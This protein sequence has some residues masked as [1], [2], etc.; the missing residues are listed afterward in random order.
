MTLTTAEFIAGV[1]VLGVHLF[2][3]N[4]KYEQNLLYG[5]FSS[6]DNLRQGFT[7]AHFTKF[8]LARYCYALNAIASCSGTRT[9]TSSSMGLFATLLSTSH[10]IC[11]YKFSFATKRLTISKL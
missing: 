5:S 4:A 6:V 3:T 11:L 7:G 8:T 9:G 2:G 1:I 10:C